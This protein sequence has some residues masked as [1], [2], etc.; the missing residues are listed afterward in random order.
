MQQ[1]SHYFLGVAIDS[2]LL[3]CSKEL[4]VS[5]PGALEFL[6]PNQPFVECVATI[7]S[8]ALKTR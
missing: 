1:C 3:C 7:V 5:Q 8:F 2:S 6:M 4:A